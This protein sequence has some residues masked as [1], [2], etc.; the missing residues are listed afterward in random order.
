[1]DQNTVSTDEHT[2]FAIDINHLSSILLFYQQDCLTPLD[3]TTALHVS[4]FNLTSIPLH[5][6]LRF[7]GQKLINT[8]ANIKLTLLLGHAL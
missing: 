3:P 8:F 1:M 2:H 7:A 5:L 6:S 4:K